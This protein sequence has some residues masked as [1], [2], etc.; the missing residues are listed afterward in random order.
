MNENPKIILIANS[1]YTFDINSHI[2]EQDIMVRF[3]LPK[4]STLAPTGQR[5]DLLFLANT[6]DVVQKKMKPNS[7]FIKFTKT[8]ENPLT[9]IFPYSDE[10]I[11]TIKPL[12]KRKVFIFLKKLTENF[13]NIEYINFLNNLGH[14][15]NVIP[16]DYYLNL[17]HQVD[18]DT[19]N[20]LSTGIIAM[21]YFLK[22]PKY[23]NYDLYLHGFSFE[24]WDGHA[25]DKEK[26]HIEKLIQSN[27]IHIFQRSNHNQ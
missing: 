13:N 3:N 26:Q 1:D 2:S 25:W 14:K 21:N 6:V 5:T 17:K 19:K 9:I 16:D 22:K 18:P 10:L 12:Y 7:K 4:A 27:R 15:V 20:I 11:K 23:Q 8:V 24:G